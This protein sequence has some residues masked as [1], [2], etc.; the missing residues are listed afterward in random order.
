MISSAARFHNVDD[1]IQ[2]CRRVTSGLVAWIESAIKK[3]LQNLVAIIETSSINY[4][5][6]LAN[7]RDRMGLS[8]AAFVFLRQAVASGASTHSRPFRI[9][10]RLHPDSY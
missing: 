2:G 10:S 1:S 8:S 7:S 6:Q 4:K 3:F 9:D 5:H